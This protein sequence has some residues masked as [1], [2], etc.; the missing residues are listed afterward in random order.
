MRFLP[1]FFDLTAGPV[2]LVGAGAQALA[3]LRILQAAGAK[4]R[5]YVRS[6]EEAEA[7]D[8]SQV[9]LRIGLPSDDDFLGAIALVASV[10][11][12]TDE[13]LAK[14]ARAMNLAGEHRRPAGSLDFH[15]S[16]DRGSR[17]CGGRGRHLRHL[18]GAG[19]APARTHRGD[20]AGA[21]RRFR[22]L[23]GPLSRTLER[24][25]PSRFLHPRA[26]GR[27]SST[28]RSPRCFCPAAKPRRKP[29]SS[30]RSSAPARTFPRRVMCRSWARDRAIRIC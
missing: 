22:K 3:K 16:R 12:D 29:L 11:K 10:D 20:I 25:A 27:R 30:S 8:V 18:A 28:V 23:H 7:A 4:V 24:A 14:R 6:Q 17:R 26:S 5:W 21:D 13:A 9:R 15:L 1:L 19:A 2:L